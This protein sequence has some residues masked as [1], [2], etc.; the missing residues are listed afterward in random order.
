MSD[1]LLLSGGIDS[2]AI[3]AWLRPSLCLTVD[4]GQRAADAEVRA[5]RQICTSLNLPHEVLQIDISMLGCGDMSGGEPNNHSANTEFWPF[6]NQFLITLAAMKAMKVGIDRV[7]IGSVVTDKRH[8]DGTEEFRS[9]L[10]K[11]LGLQEGAVQLFAPAAALTTTELVRQSG[12]LP[13]I[14]GW[15]HSCHVS[16]YACNCCNGCS[17]HSDVM[18]ELGWAR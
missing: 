3:A 9:H 8:A 15:T 2:A 17:K 5:S 6:R 7:L 18:E 10:N 14:L 4:Y 1:L 11:T 13:E 16:E 12:I